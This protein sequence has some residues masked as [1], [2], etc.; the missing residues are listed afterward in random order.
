MRAAEGLPRRAGRRSTSRSRSGRSD[1]SPSTPRSSSSAISLGLVDGP[2]VHLAAVRVR[3]AQQG[4]VDHGEPDRAGAA[5]GPAAATADRAAAAS[6]PGQAVQPGPGA[7]PERRRLRHRRAQPVAAAARAAVEPAPPRTRPGTPGA[8]PVGASSTRE[9]RR[10]RRQPTSAR[11][12]IRVSGQRVEHL[13]P[14]A[15]SAPGRGPAPPPARRPCSAA[16]RPVPSVVRSSVASWWTTATP[17]ALACTSS[18]R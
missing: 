6:G 1:S 7:Q 13:A 4:R 15:G 17:S 11:S 16:M 5:A 10:R 12:V 2:D 3:G 9:R 8:R 18:S 14:A